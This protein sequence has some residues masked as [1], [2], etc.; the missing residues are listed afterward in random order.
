MRAA[1]AP[2]DGDT[3][4]DGVKNGVAWALGAANPTANATRLLPVIDNSSDLTYVLFTFN[5][6][7]AAN[8]DAKTA[9]AVEFG[10]NLT[11]WTAAVENGDD[12]IIN[13]TPGN[14]KDSVVVKLKRTTLAQGGKIFARLKVLVTP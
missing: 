12:V 7:D 2:A 6:S 4:N 10:N 14:H 11:G 1:G 5:R 3:N 8:G 9:I 13:V